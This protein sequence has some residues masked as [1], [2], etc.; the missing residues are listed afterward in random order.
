MKKVLI[1]TYYW[2]PMGGGGV[3]RWLKFTKYLRNFNWEPVIYT[4][5]NADV[6]N[7][8]ES[9]LKEI[10]ENL[11]V[12]KLPIWEPFDLYKRFTGKGK[13]EKVQPGF[14]QESDSR[15]IMQ[16]ISVWIRGNLFIP[17]AKKFWIRPSV[18]YLTDLIKKENIEVIISTGPPHSTHIIALKVK[19]KTGVK[20]LADF[21]DPW[22]NIDYYNKL[23]LTR[24]A[25][26]RHRNLEKKVLSYADVV[27]TVS[28]SWARDFEL[29][30]GILPEVIT[31]GFDPEDF[32]IEKTLTN[33]IL[34]ITH[35][36]SLNKDRNPHAF[37]KALKRINDRNSLEKKIRVRLIG[38]TDVSVFSDV[39]DMGLSK[40]VDH[41]SN[42][43]HSAVIQEIRNSD[44]LLLPLNDTPN[45]DGVI[46]GKLYEYLACKRPIICI[47]KTSGDS[48]YI[49]SESNSGFTFEFNDIDGIE[50]CLEQYLRL[51]QQGEIADNSDAPD[52]FSR[53][54]LAGKIGELLNRITNQS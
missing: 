36:G 22:T 47:G 9:L 20:W 29:T 6:A 35:I 4:P 2:P 16:K 23:M 12:H 39:E 34:T 1:I 31:N 15:P 7:Y 18:K 44:L 30:T 14:L 52:K 37:W 8:D 45:I 25:D 19:E 53:M 13:D 24:R 33:E 3:Q 42:L 5:A 46:P 43:P 28:R 27:V 21:R 38:P 17:D 51:F 54:K 26:S 11:E 50:E 48:A 32:E 40:L 49:I 41:E 10:P